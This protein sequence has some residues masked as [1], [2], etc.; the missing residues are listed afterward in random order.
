M[1]IPQQLIKANTIKAGNC[2]VFMS[3]CNS[4][5]RL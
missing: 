2:V 5:E 3:Q 4:L 1:K